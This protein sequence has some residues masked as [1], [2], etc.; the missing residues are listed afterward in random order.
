MLL[1]Q[2]GAMFIAS[3]GAGHAYCPTRGAL[4]APAWSNVFATC[5]VGHARFPA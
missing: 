1:A 3:S 5:E 4:L 2:L